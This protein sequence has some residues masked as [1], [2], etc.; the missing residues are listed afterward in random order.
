MSVMPDVCMH[1]CQSCEKYWWHE[2]RVGCHLNPESRCAECIVR[3]G[4]QVMIRRLR[5]N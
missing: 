3:I 2:G 4:R 1:L 5:S